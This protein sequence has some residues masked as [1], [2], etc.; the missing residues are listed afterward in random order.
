MSYAPIV[1]FVYNRL[2]HVHKT[3]QAL[4]KNDLAS[5]SDLFIYSD[6]PMSDLSSKSKVTEVRDFIKNI[7]GFKNVII[8]ESKENKGL[9]HSI[10]KGVTDTVNRY[11]KVIVLEDDLETSRNLLRYMNEAL[12]RY[13]EEPQ[14]MQISGHMFDVKIKSK[15][16]AVFLPFITS[17]GWGTWKRAWDCF[18]PSMF[19]YTQLKHSKKLIHHFNLEGAYNY[20]SMLDSQFHGQID[21]WAIRWYLSVFFNDGLILYP[22]RSFVRNIGFDGSGTHCGVSTRAKG[23]PLFSLVTRKLF[24]FPEVCLDLKTYS[25]VKE[26][27]SGGRVSS[28]TVKS[29]FWKKTFIFT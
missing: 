18:D 11:G 17:W 26:F 25:I 3:V 12:D 5:E 22:T 2:D 23:A 6:G 19:N 13:E 27:L 15:T 8:V 9:A 14:V 20:F 16:D 24:Q 1:L 21:S 4:Q 10:I 28:G 29:G 7:T